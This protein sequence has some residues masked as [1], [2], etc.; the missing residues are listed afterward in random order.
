M[1]N[2]M[3][4][5]YL[6]DKELR[7]KI[8]TII[9]PISLQAFLM[10][11]DATIDSIMLGH[12]GQEA[13]ASVSLAGQI[14]FVYGMLMGTCNMAFSIFV[15]Q[16]WGKRD[17]R[18]AEKLLGTSC[19]ISMLIALIFVSIALLIPKFFMKIFTNEPIFIE[20]GASY[21]RCLSV[22]YFFL[23]LSQS[24]S[25]MC[26]CSG[27][28]RELT[29]I[30][31][32][33]VPLDIIFNY[34]FI[35][36]IAGYCRW[37][38][39]G[40]AVATTIVRFITLVLTYFEFRRENLFRI[41]WLYFRYFARSLFKHVAKYTAPILGNLGCHA[42]G[43]IMAAIIIGHLQPDAVA[44]NSLTRVLIHASAIFYSGVWSGVSI[45]IGNT[46]GSGDI[47]RAKDIGRKLL[48]TSFIGGVLSALLLFA[49]IPFVRYFAKMTPAA[50]K[51]TKWM[52]LISAP[53]MVCQACNS[54]FFSTFNTGGESRT[55]F[56][57][58][59][60]AV[61]AIIVPLDLLCVFVFHAPIL[62]LF[63]VVY[64]D[65]VVKA[66]M[67]YWYYRKEK[68][69]KNLTVRDKVSASSR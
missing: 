35:F 60:I 46:L 55:S 10:N 44:A 49:S 25:V 59:F 63:F 36:G 57:L 28:A 12:V 17:I 20:L 67:A 2:R 64:M 8:W 42:I 22:S 68:W 3:F 16:Y 1:E 24:L 15:A 23:S 7:Q 21:L 14:Q 58:D 52:L 19:Q 47:A 62:L 9:L 6:P 26:R 56:K 69:A 33:T 18:T 45:I 5:S 66:P 34:V 53:V 43:I 29:A 30:S 11:V 48:T 39:A 65:E 4:S 31:F 40:A 27:H 61:V 38:V 13:L 54:F 50:M 51:L 32:A 41:K 37:G